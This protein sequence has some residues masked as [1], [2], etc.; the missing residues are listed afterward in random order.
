[1]LP[2]QEN[3]EVAQKTLLSPL[4]LKPSVRSSSVDIVSNGELAVTVAEG[5]VLPLPVSMTGK[6]PGEILFPRSADGGGTY[7]THVIGDD[8]FAGMF[9]GL[10]GASPPSVCVLY[11]PS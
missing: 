11:L 4:P 8:Q 1:M 10:V 6:P 2:E 9:L 5:L 3:Q 7:Q